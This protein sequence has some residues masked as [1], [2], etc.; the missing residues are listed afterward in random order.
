M[1]IKSEKQA[2]VELCQAQDNVGKMG[3][4]LLPNSSNLCYGWNGKGVKSLALNKKKIGE[5]IGPLDFP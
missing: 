1:K 3:S 5:A 4:V 2:G